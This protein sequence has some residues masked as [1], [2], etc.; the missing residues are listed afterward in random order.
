MDSE[1]ESGQ[2]GIFVAWQFLKCV[3]PDV[4]QE[5]NLKC[6]CYAF[7]PLFLFWVARVH[8]S[9]VPSLPKYIGQRWSFGGCCDLT[10]PGKRT[11]CFPAL[12]QDFEDTIWQKY[13]L[14]KGK[15]NRFFNQ[16]RPRHNQKKMVYVSFS[17][18]N[19]IVT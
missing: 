4:W 6:K 1:L 8:M 14:L 12:M 3:S 16:P 9:Q 19:F 18:C 11:N 13:Y 17:N 2:P 15:S 10:I 7:S 5:G